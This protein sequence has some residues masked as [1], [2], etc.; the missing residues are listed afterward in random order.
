[1][2]RRLSLVVVYLVLALAAMACNLSSLGGGNDQQQP[3]HADAPVVEIRVPANNTPFAEGTRVIIQA[4]ANDAGAGVSRVELLVDDVPAGSSNAPAAQGQPAYVA[5][6]EWVAQGIGL[7]SITVVAYRA[8]N[9]ASA[10]ATINVSV[11]A[12]QPP[13]QPPTAT[14]TT[15]PTVEATQPPAGGAEQQQP[16][17]VPPSATPSAP[18]GVTTIGLN[19]R[20]G[21]STL[22]P[23][24]G[25]FLAGSDVELVGRNQDSS[26]WVVPFG[27]RQGWI[28]AQ[29]VTATGDTA[30]LPVVQ[31]PPP[32]PTATPTPIIPTAPPAP[33][34]VFTSTAP[35]GGVPAGTVVR[36]TWET[37]NVRE[38]YLNNEGVPGTGFREVTINSNTTYTLRVVKLD[39]TTEERSITINVSGSGGSGIS[40]TSTAPNGPVPAGT[41]IRF[42]WETSNVREV[43][44]Q[45]AGV[46]GTGFRE[47]TVNST[48]TFTL[49]VVRADGVV[50]ERHITVTVQ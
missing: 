50:D 10:P 18:R 49:R 47:V 37:S 21:P 46:E 17:A 4:V 43:Y 14:P 2:A 22:Y 33:N 35:A 8:D 25:A 29:F 39:G 15:A 19:V 44:F 45:G 3:G 9:T 6:L 11:V 40:F 13:T 31:A 36:L 28:S 41:V 1:M 16:T 5:N 38:V 48:T 12:G 23:V 20:S 27:S 24:I 32:P 34:I 30:S 42:M 7:H 26:W